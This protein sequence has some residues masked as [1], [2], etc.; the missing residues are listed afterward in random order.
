MRDRRQVVRETTGTG[1]GATERVRRSRRRLDSGGLRRVLVNR[2]G[3]CVD[4]SAVSNVAIVTDD[5]ADFLRLS[6]ILKPLPRLEPG[7]AANEVSGKHPR[8]DPDL[9]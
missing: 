6:A 5:M 2:N 1:E 8:D 7:D 3:A 9:R 4:W